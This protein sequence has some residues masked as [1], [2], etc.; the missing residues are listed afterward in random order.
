MKPKSYIDIININWVRLWLNKR[1]SWERVESFD[2]QA[3]T[4]T[5]KNTVTGIVKDYRLS[6]TDMKWFSENLIIIDESLINKIRSELN[7]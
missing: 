5:V 2:Y 1:I 4:A 6:F 7:A 3:L